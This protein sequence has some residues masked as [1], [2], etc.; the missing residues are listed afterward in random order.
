MNTYSAM[1]SSSALRG[2]AAL[3]AAL[4]QHPDDL[5]AALDTW[6]AALR[7]YVTGQQRSARLKQQ[8]FVPS[9]RLAEELC[10]VVLELVRRV[11]HR[12]MTA[13][14]TASPSR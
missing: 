5:D 3:G 12:R 13:Q 11:V 9:S 6:E 10:S 7:R 4:Q 14:V 1:G 2:G 8:R